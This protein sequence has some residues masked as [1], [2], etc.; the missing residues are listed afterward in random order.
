MH[1]H[2]SDSTKPPALPGL[3][4]AD[5]PQDD[6]S[7]SKSEAH[8]SQD[9]TAQETD[10][11][12]NSVYDEPGIAPSIAATTS[13]DDNIEPD[14]WL[15]DE[16]YA[17]STSTRYL[18]SIA[19]D[20]RRGVEE[21][22]R[23]YAAYG[24]HQSWLPIDDEELDRN[25]LQHYKFALLFNNKLFVAPVPSNPQ[26]I[27]DLGTGSGI[28]AIDMADKYPSADVIGVDIAA[29][30][31]DLIPPNLTFEIDDIENDWLWGESKF[32]FIHGRELIMAIRDWPRLLRQAYRALKPGAYIQLSA[33]VPDFQ[34]DDG[35]LPP[36]SAYIETGQI[37]FDM[38][39]R[40]GVSGKEPL[41]WVEYLQEAGYE[42][43]V[44]K[45]YKIPTNPWPKDERLKRIGALE[46]THY[47]DGIMNVFARGYTGILGGDEA[48]F[49]ILMAR[50]RREVEDRNMHS[51]VPFH[52]VYA[53][54][55]GTL[56]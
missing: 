51:W 50:A 7:L 49:Q 35:T 54:K 27:L 24:M 53:K 37:Y 36:D 16:G 21:N 19:S 22:G 20:I 6:D 15:S 46:L 18:S 26:K 8:S 47:R 1:T 23:L 39:E 14:L 3:T 56:E 55:P 29:T 12:A 44:H 52:V 45:I 38:S 33:S 11:D 28:W 4:N 42:D 17:E 5:H 9:A 41:K 25:D 30:Q 10:A 34:S 13:T 32:D 48:Y 40:V 43:I 31:P 2:E